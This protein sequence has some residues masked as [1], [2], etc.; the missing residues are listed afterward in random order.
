M[1][2]LAPAP[3]RP[4]APGRPVQKMF[5]L[6]GLPPNPGEIPAEGTP[7]PTET[8]RAPGGRLPARSTLPIIQA[9]RKLA[10]TA[11]EWGQLAGAQTIIDP[12]YDPLLLALNV[13]ESADLPKL[14]DVM[15]TNTTGFGLD[16]RPLFPRLD[17]EGRPLD[18]PPE[19]RGEEEAIRLFLATANPALGFAGVLDL[20]DRDVEATG[21]GFAEVLRDRTG[22]VAAL[23]HV[24]G[25]TVRLG[26]LHD[27]V[28]VTVPYRNPVSGKLETVERWRR[29]RTFV[30]V[31]ESRV[32]WFRE[33]GD[34]YAVNLQTGERRPQ[35]WG[36]DGA[37]NALDASELIH[38][39]IYCPHSPYGVPRWVGAAP[40]IRAVRSADETIA[41]FFRDAPIGAK[42][43][44]VAGG[45]FR[46]DSLKRMS[47]Q[48]DDMARG[49]E[50]A[51]RIVTLEAETTGGSELDETRD[52]AP[53]VVVD[54]LTFEVP[55]DWYKEGGLI[56]RGSRAIAAT[57]RL[58][59]VYWGGSDDFSRA[60]ARSAVATTEEQLFVP[61]RASRWEQW[62]NAELLPSM[63]V[64]FWELRLKGAA[65]TDDAELLKGLGPLIDGG[66]A[67]PNALIA[68]LNGLTRQE[69]APIS[70]PWGERPLA[71][72]LELIKQGR[73]PSAP[74]SPE[75]VPGDA[76]AEV[77][78]A[79]APQP[80][81]VDAVV[82]LLQEVGSGALTRPAAE[83]IL[84]A[85]LGLSPEAA[86]DVVREVEGPAPAPPGPAPSPTDLPILAPP[87][88]AAV[89]KRLATSGR[90]LATLQTIRDALTGLGV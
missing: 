49:T 37:G 59:P 74:L 44:L 84:V 67:S 57:F 4:L 76:P 32:V 5:G 28:R 77:A 86:A 70:E 51:F 45:V 41:I 20:V 79:A 21:N 48:I 58:P 85:F 75:E 60:A 34:P 9:S 23:E 78:P 71:L 2:K 22:R 27:P 35:S 7:A 88:R 36:T 25:Y 69:I 53:R 13:E 19:A 43:A 6:G 90:V 42:L 73:D 61:L 12:P 40:K 81:A 89:Q 62:F 64:N 30:Q 8:G 15:A 66:G 11:E 54:D 65:T 87:D 10:T 33:Y 14:I 82:R 3:S 31:V 83:R 68:F 55:A 17:A 56:E 18:P 26:R 47:D 39:R 52:T 24:P 50:N 1:S 63:G 16:L 29:F 38:R 72:V 46:P 80:G